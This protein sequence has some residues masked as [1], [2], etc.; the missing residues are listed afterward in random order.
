MPNC[1]IGDVTGVDTCC[2]CGFDGL[3]HPLHYV[4]ILDDDADQW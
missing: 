4:N 2:R 1:Q 3:A